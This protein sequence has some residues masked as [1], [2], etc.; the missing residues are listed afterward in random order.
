M[1]KYLHFKRLAAFALFA[2][3]CTGIN[4]KSISGGV[5][6]LTSGADAA[7]VTAAE[8]AGVTKIVLDGNFTDG[9]TSGDLINVNGDRTS[10]KEIDMSKAVMTGTPRWSFTSF[11]N[12]KTITWP[13]AGNITN[14]PIQAFNNCGIEEVHIPGYITNIESHAFNEPS[15]AHY[16]KRVYFDEWDSNGDGISDVNMTIGYQAFSNNYG[17]TD[18]YIIAEGTINAD[19]MAFPEWS[20]YG[21]ADPTRDLAYLHF[22]EDKA[23]SYANLQHTLDEATASND[24]SF[25]DWLLEHYRQANQSSVRNGWWEFISAG[26]EGD[27][28]TPSFLRTYSHPTLDH[29]VPPGVKAYIVNNIETDANAKKVTLTLKKVNVIPANTGVIL[30]GGANSRA[31][32]GGPGLVMQV[33]NY[34]GPVMDVNDNMNRNYL[35]ATAADPAKKDETAYVKPYDVQYGVIYR[36]FLMGKFSNT[37]SGKK[38]KK[39]NGNYGTGDGLNGGDWVGFFRTKE[40]YFGPNKAYLKLDQN[41]YNE[42]DGGEIIINVTAQNNSGNTTEY[43]R[44]EYDGK[45][46]TTPLDESVLKREGYWH[47][48]KNGNPFYW[49]DLW[50]TRALKDGFSMAKYNGELEDEDWMALL[51]SITNGISTVKVEENGNDAI[52]TLQG[53]KVNNPTKG[54]FI[55]NGKKYIVK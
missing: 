48:G 42:V 53:V 37:D 11:P 30:F 8:L 6:T 27:P 23:S 10:L 45:G 26:E 46:G 22:P 32:N 13:T 12:L 33:V 29:L 20:T 24:A 9:W 49:K 39:E 44:V 36:T 35:T 21:H 40:G 52:Y 16:L 28:T 4:A 7:S 15:D 5:M 41:V 19:N 1:K 38:Y 50:G 34:T 54:I 25:H 2:L 47:L 55:K 51:E 17:L 14:I 3:A 18:V 31:K 43:Y